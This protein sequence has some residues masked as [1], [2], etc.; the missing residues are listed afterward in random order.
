[1]RRYKRCQLHLSP[2]GDFVTAVVKYWWKLLRGKTMRIAAVLF[3]AIALSAC[4][5]SYQRD[6]VT[7][8][9]S[10]TQLD[11]NVWK[12]TFRGN[13]YTRGQRAEDLA[14]LRCAELTVEKGYTHFALAGASSDKETSTVITPTSSY[15][16]G[17]A[18]VS[19]NNVY[20]QARTH[21]YGGQT[22]FISHPSTTN[23]VVMF[24][25]KPEIQ[26]MVFNARFICQ[27]IGQKYD[28][29]CGATK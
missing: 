11:E 16:T 21:T 28:V 20:G 1:M 7:G 4:A 14:L 10:E 13:G 5:T 2:Y 15:T 6:G 22:I 17:S 9:F 3:A 12:V 19:G 26:G 29:A 24:R 25:E 27:S 23:T 8:G 18:Y